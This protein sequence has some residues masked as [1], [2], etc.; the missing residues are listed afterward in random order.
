MINVIFFIDYA[1]S[2]T[3]YKIVGYEVSGH[4]LYDDYGKDIICA[5]VSSSVFMCT[6]CLTDI[7]HISGKI[8]VIDNEKIG[9]KV[10]KEDVDECQTI[11]RAL[12]LHLSGL[13]KQY[14]NFLVVKHLEV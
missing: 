11:F 13:E 2:T 10:Q 5:A 6:N 8:D 1:H 4:A 14:G 7:L 3:G 9:V 12:E